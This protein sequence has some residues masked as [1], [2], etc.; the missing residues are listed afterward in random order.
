[1][2]KQKMIEGVSEDC[3]LTKPVDCIACIKSKSERPPFSHTRPRAQNKLENIHVD[4]SGIVRGYVNDG[5]LYYILFTDDLTGMKFV[6][7]LKSKDKTSV[8]NA[9]LAFIIFAERQSERKVKCFTLDQGS[10]FF[11]SLFVPYCREQGIK[12]E[13]Y[14]SIQTCLQASVLKPSTPL[15]TLIIELFPLLITTAQ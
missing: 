14:S 11:N 2:I 5:Y 6:Y 10:E 1:M 4:L 13:H 9:I 7:F 3:D 8:F 12:H 15:S